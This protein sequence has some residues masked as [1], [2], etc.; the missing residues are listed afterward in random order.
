MTE[1][2]LDLSLS[3]AAAVIGLG[4]ILMRV[5]SRAAPPTL[6]WIGS[7]LVVIGTLGQLLVGTVEVAGTLSIASVIDVA[8]TTFF[9]SRAI[10]AIGAAA[11]LAVVHPTARW[12]MRWPRIPAMVAAIVFALAL[13]AQGHAAEPHDR[14]LVH[15]LHVGAASLWI[16][17]L[18]ALVDGIDRGV[19]S[20]RWVLA[21][22][23]L[24]LWLVIVLLVTGTARM[25]AHVGSL[26]D[27]ASSYGR[28]LVFKLALAACALGFAFRHRRRTLP[29]LEEGGAISRAFVRDLTAEL[30]LVFCTLMAATALAQQ[31]PPRE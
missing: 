21:F 12:R 10:A 2:L 9:G 3:R 17:G 24:A 27:L 5:R 28:V 22:S 11:A 20:P 31:P 4:L 14:T 1:H 7:V 15:A 19:A 8:R 6:G 29:L 16:G 25:L 23:R 13:S 18:A 26:A 30:V